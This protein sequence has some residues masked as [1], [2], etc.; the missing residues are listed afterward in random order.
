MEILFLFTFN[1][2]TQQKLPTNVNLKE[3]QKNIDTYVPNLKTEAKKCKQIKVDLPKNKVRFRQTIQHLLVAPFAKHAKTFP[4]HPPPTQ[5]TPPF[6]APPPCD[7]H[8]CTATTTTTKA[9]E[10][11]KWK[12]L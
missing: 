8:S 10:A 12:L 4:T 5:S 11:A 1:L 7:D 6:S 2:K 3:T 9:R